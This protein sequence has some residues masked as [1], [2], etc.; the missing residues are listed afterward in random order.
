MKKHNSDSHYYPLN[1]MTLTGQGRV[2]TVPDEAVIRLGVQTTGENLFD[3]QAEN[4]RIS[5]TILEALEQIGITD[6]KTHQYS[7]NKY[8]DYEN[9]NRIDRG[10]TVRNIL[11]I[12]TKDIDQIGM[13]IDTAVNYGANVVEFIS[14]EL[15]NQQYHY[16]QALNQ[17]ISNAIQKAK[18]ISMSLGIKMDPIPTH[19]I[20]NSSLSISPQQ[21][22]RELAATPI[23][24]G[25][26]QIDAN[27]TV[28]FLY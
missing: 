9:G 11:E 2:T 17:A 23:V 22:Q 1:T 7:I 5:Q 8:Y 28:E 14:F 25:N 24:P 21:F 10:Y 19:I 20:E 16:Q 4:K 12:R 3:I 6:I 15:S 26:L 18:S 13:I 27:V